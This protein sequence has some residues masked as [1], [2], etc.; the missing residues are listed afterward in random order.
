MPLLVVL[1]LALCS[2]ALTIV[3]TVLITWQRTKGDPQEF[4][5][6]LLG[7][8]CGYIDQSG[9]LVIDLKNNFNIDVF[10][11]ST[12][13]AS[14]FVAGRA[15]LDDQSSEHEKYICFDSSGKKLDLPKDVSLVGAVSEGLA[16]FSKWNPSNSGYF[17]ASWNV[18]LAPKWAYAGDFSEGLAAV[19]TDNAPF[20]SVHFGYINQ[21]GNLVIKDIYSSARKFKEG[22]AV[23]RLGTTYGA[24]DRT[25][26][27]IVPA[28]YNSIY[29]CSQGIIVA[30]KY[31]SEQKP[32]PPHKIGSLDVERSYLD[33]T[34]NLKFSRRMHFEPEER[35]LSN[36]DKMR[37]ETYFPELDF[38]YELDSDASFAEDRAPIKVG[39]KYGYINKDGKVVIKPLYDLA[40]AFSE[41][42]AAVVE[43]EHF[44]FID[45]N[46]NL[47]TDFKYCSVHGFSEGLAAVNSYG[48]QRWGYINKKGQEVIAPRF[49]NPHDF[50]EGKAQV[51]LPSKPY[52]SNLVT[53][54]TQ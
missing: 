21:K 47:I 20:F 12:S 49:F 3:G 48:K 1:G 25:G 42:R 10:C 54:K 17:D 19:R 4:A 31:L 33:K 44:A 45:E 37:P 7:G 36:F 22:I 28:E 35:T 50:H 13:V 41:G 23:V 16:S 38:F 40:F 24:I 39:K 6:E 2:I 30:D 14:D 32:N 51:G 53:S 5:F 11:H 9:K 46:G 18:I 8:D 27:L 15:T 52:W 26:K 43:N 29:D 34:G